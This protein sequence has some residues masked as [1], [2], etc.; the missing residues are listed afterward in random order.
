MCPEEYQRMYKGKGLPEETE[1]Y[2]GM[3][4]NIDDN[5]GKLMSRLTD[6]GLDDNTILIFMT[7][8]GGTGGVRVF[9]AGM[10]GAKGS[11]YQG[12]TRV[13]AFFR[14]RGEFP[15]SDRSQLTAHID[16]FPTLAELAGAR[17]PDNVKL[18]GHS[19]VP[20]LKDDKVSWPDRVLFTHVGRWATGQAAAAKYLKCSMRTARYSMV[21]SGPAK[22]WELYDLKTDP[23]EKTDVAAQHPEIVKKLNAAYDRWWD[24]ILPCLENENAAPPEVAPYKVSYWQ[25]YGGGP[26][27]LP[28]Q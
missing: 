8:N 14:W 24:E 22:K 23:G 28:R 6:W 13:P 20:L 11:P 27:K 21:S 2:F 12:G 17:T 16:I 19:L 26:G 3:V 18:D 4:T 10:R 25:Q 5:I 7:D 15:P 1:K 9:N